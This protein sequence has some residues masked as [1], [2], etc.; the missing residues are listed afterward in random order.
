MANKFLTFLQNE[1][2]KNYFIEL[3][4]K[5]KNEQQFYS[6][7]PNDTLRYRALEFF[8]PEETKLIILGQDPYYLANQADG[9]AFSTQLNKC[10]RSLA[11]MI[12]E[13]LKDYPQ[14]VVETYSLNSWAKQG[15]LL[16]NTVL[17]VREKQ[18]NSHQNLGW[19]QFILNLIKFVYLNNQNTL[20]ALWGNQALK[21][22]QPLIEQQIIKPQNMIVCSHPS[23]LSYARGKVSFKD[24]NFY[25]KVNQRLT[26]PIDF[27]LRKDDNDYYIK[28]IK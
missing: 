19:S 23:P 15:V 13:L 12:K 9:L 26:I 1:K 22:I 28:R 20:I 3:E 4:Q 17:S 27:S 18:P 24:F 11:N 25:K 6:I 7:Y 8:E 5:L 2:Q 21:F 16:L 10:P 14:S